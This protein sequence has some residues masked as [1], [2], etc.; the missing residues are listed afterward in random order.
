M[1]PS[2]PLNTAF[3]LPNLSPRSSF[4]R[5]DSNKTGNYIGHSGAEARPT[6]SDVDHSS[7]PP[8]SEHRKS[9]RRSLS[10]RIH[11]AASIIR[12]KSA[13]GARSEETIS[14]KSAPPLPNGGARRENSNTSSD[15]G[16]PRFRHTSLPLPY[17]EE[18]TAGENVYTDAWVWIE[19]YVIEILLTSNVSRSRR[20]V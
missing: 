20:V 11:R 16:G 19:T 10:T 8:E 18:R 12:P 2:S 14:W 15:V 4:L 6:S 7:P 5:K 9:L 13:P 1:A 17:T 3:S